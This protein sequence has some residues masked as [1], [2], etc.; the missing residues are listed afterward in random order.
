MQPYWKSITWYM[1]WIE[2]IDNG[3]VS[4]RLSFEDETRPTW[5]STWV[6]HAPQQSYPTVD[7][8]RKKKLKES[9]DPWPSRNTLPLLIPFRLKGNGYGWRLVNLLES[10]DVPDIDGSNVSK[11]IIIFWS[12]KILTDNMKSVN[13]GKE[14]HDVISSYLFLPLGVIRDFE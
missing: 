14:C 9:C 3:F 11:R 6:T 2:Q 5:T 1:G 7:P 12:A 13:G 4:A 8:T 10:L